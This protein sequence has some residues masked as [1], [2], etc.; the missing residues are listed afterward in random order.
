[1]RI[2]AALT[3][4]FL[5]S[6]CLAALVGCGRGGEDKTTTTPASKEEKDGKGKDGKEEKPTGKKALDAAKLAEEFQ[7]DAEAANTKYLDQAM[8]VEDEVF[9]LDVR[10]RGLVLRGSEKEPPALSVR[11]RAG[12]TAAAMDRAF[13]EIT[14]GQKVLVKGVYKPPEKKSDF[15]NLE[16]ADY[17]LLSGPA[18][19]KTTSFALAKEFADAPSATAKKY[20]DRVV[21]LNGKIT[22]LKKEEFTV[23][24]ELV[25]YEGFKVVA[26][27][28]LS[29]NLEKV[30][31][32]VDDEVV[33]RGRCDNFLE[34][35][36]RI[37]FAHVLP[38]K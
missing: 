1:M 18:L 27:L 21:V 4:G 5:A 35:E 9:E 17:T 22:G 33:L 15:P 19:V 16:E 25:G 23:K 13:L 3:W 29:V 34:K 10:T 31:L 32:K 20:L 38:G 28:D 2:T 30:I 8:E 11:V 36:V 6:L 12:L 26:E 37:G 14:R 7:F 24:L